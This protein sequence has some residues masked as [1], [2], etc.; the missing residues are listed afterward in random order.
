MYCLADYLDIAELE[1]LAL[2]NC[3]SILQDAIDYASFIGPITHALDNTKPNDTG[4]RPQ[5]F[6]SC[7]HHGSIEMC[8]EL[9]AVLQGKEPLAWALQVEGCM[10]QKKFAEQAQAVE[11]A[12][13]DTALQNA[14]KYDSLASQMRKL[15]DADRKKKERYESTLRLLNQ[16]DKCRNGFCTMEFGASISVGEPSVLHCKRCN[17]GHT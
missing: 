15:E 7:S 14:I 1:A 17:C 5:I 9:V 13:K 12:L 8:V 16:Y 6:R 4:L 10:K 11:N 2:I 3:T